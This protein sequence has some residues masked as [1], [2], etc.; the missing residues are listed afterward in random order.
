MK[1]GDDENNKRAVEWSKVE[2]MKAN[3]ET[4]TKP[5]FAKPEFY[6]T[7]LTLGN[8]MHRCGDRVGWTKRFRNSESRIWGLSQKGILKG[9]F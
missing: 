6:F 8:S 2:D 4:K 1:S 7:H 3:E 5:V 9:F